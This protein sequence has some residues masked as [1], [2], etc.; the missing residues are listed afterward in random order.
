MKLLAIARLKRENLKLKKELKKLRKEAALDHLT[1][2]YNNLALS[3]FLEEQV[4]FARRYKLP[5][6]IILIDFDNLKK[7]NDRHGHLQGNM[8]IKTAVRAMKSCMRK[9]DILGRWTSGEEFLVIL[10]ETNKIGAVILAEKIRN[11]IEKTRVK[12]ASKNLKHG[13]NKITVSL[14]VSELISNSK[15][16]LH[17]ADL[18]LYKAKRLGK[19]RVEVA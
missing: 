13:Y 11:E 16:M 6:S 8:A 17:E 10:P 5:L 15:N 1:N 9:S 3:R 4:N 12:P 2:I 18:A 14:G 19:N 7:Y